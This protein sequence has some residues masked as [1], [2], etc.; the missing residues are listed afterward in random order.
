VKD[1]AYIPVISSEENHPY[2]HYHKY[3]RLLKDAF[4]IMALGEGGCSHKE[5]LLFKTSGDFDKEKRIMI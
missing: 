2:L 1:Q 3:N 5:I 4:R